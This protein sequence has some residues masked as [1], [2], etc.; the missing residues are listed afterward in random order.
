MWRRVASP[1]TSILAEMA[2]N[3]ANDA[4]A[5]GADAGAEATRLAAVAADYQDRS[6][7]CLARG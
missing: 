1:T 6:A 3:F 2:Q 7:A 4:D 5:G